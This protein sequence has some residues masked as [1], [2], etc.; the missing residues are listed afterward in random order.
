MS[1]DQIAMTNKAPM[2]Q[3]QHWSLR[4]WTFIGHWCLVIGIFY[5]C[6]GCQQMAKVGEF[7]KNLGDFFTG[8]TPIN[9]A[10]KMEDRYFADERR[11]GINNLADRS[12]GLR[13]PYTKRYQQIAEFDSDWLVRATAIRALNRARDSSAT[14][15]LIKALSDQSDIVR[16]EAAKA[17]G[18]IPDPNAVP[19]LVKIV[20]DQG[21]N[22]DVR[23][24]AAHALRHYHSLEVARTLATQLD[25]R[26][27][28]VAWQSRN[29]LVAIT[30]Q[31]LKYSTAAWLDYLTGPQK[32]FG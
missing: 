7:G 15:V 14:P 11:L 9:A 20:S 24:W 13:E 18:N 30:G 4:R 17:L 6:S 32:P 19:A 21:D 22:R 8:N 1:N 31:D 27:F 26:E 10:K 3:S 29:S 25:G 12:Y 2:S 5:V 28:G 16:V 23:V